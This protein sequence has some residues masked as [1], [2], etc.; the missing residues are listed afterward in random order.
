MEVRE[1]CRSV[2]PDWAGAPA[3]LSPCRFAWRLRI[4]PRAGDT[5]FLGSNFLARASVI[6]EES[7]CLLRKWNVSFQVAN[8][9]GGLCL[10][11]SNEHEDSGLEVG[12]ASA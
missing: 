5:V 10:L 1:P 2:L 3:T 4:S 12:A 9:C 6:L 8:V 11:V 7:I